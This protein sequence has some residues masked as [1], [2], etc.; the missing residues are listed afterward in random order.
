[1]KKHI[2]T[3][4]LL[5][6]GMFAFSCSNPDVDPVYNPDN[7]KASV[8]GS[9]D[10]SYTLTSDLAS[11]T[12]VTFK[13]TEA[14]FSNLKLA[15]QYTLY[16][17]LADSSFANKKSLGTT[18]DISASI[19]VTVSKLNSVLLALGAEAGTST[20]VEFEVVAEVLGESST[21]SSFTA[22]SSNTV[23]ST[24]TPYSTDIVYP[25]IW[26]IGDYCGWSFDTSQHLYSYTQD[27]VNYEGVIDFGTSAANGFKINGAGNWSDSNVNWGVDG[28]VTAPSSEASSITLI[29]SGSSGNI[30]CYSKRFYKFSF[31]NSSLLLKQMY[32]FDQLGIVGTGVG[33][34][35]D[36]VVMSF[37]SSTQEFYVD[38]TLATGLIKFRTDASWTLNFGGA[39]GT[40]V[41]GGDNIAVTAGTYRITVN[42]N[43]SN[44]LI[45]TVE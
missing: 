10:S 43:N 28:S 7:V 9:I 25:S 38:I 15:V 24:I 23:S 27:E 21:L 36:D 41:A 22:L 5:L 11:D 37:D 13:F 2:N 4:F 33:S 39:D 16:V 31:N 12:L 1:M 29:A 35:T 34:W 40:L 19:P 26:V 3:L 17:D 6:L 45:Y 32:G 8:L 44:G 30:T 18:T 14:N 42:L 20:A